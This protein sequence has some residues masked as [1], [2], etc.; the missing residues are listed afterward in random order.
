MNQPFW[1][2]SHGPEKPRVERK[3]HQADLVLF[4]TKQFNYVE[5]NPFLCRQTTIGSH[6]AHLIIITRN[7]LISSNL[8][9]PRGGRCLWRGARKLAPST[10]VYI[11]AG[12]IFPAQDNCRRP[13][14]PT[15]DGELK[16]SLFCFFLQLNFFLI[17][18]RPS[19]DD[20]RRVCSFTRFYPFPFS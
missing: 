3:K 6:N 18:K 9:P 17:L 13:H 10:P 11:T 15:R 12:L 19:R 4:T 16:F 2:A 5:N 14:T 8:P 7:Y 20:T 1:N